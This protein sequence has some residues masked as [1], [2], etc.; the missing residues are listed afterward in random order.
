MKVRKSDL[1]VTEEFGSWKA[2]C[3]YKHFES[4]AAF[5]ALTDGDFG[6]GGTGHKGHKFGARMGV[7]KNWDVG[8]I[9]YRVDDDEPAAG[10]ERRTNTLQVESV[11]KF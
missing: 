5:G 10:V 1:R 9:Y 6:G 7:M 2:F 11:V 4:D 8:V 3:F